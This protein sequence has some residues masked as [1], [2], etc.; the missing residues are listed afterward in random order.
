M[1]D[2]PDDR[3]A[4]ALAAS[5]FVLILFAQRFFIYDRM[6]TFFKL[7]LQSW[8]LL[9]VATA[10]L[11]FGAG[12]R[13]SIGRWSIPARLGAV[14]LALA[15]LFTT[16]TAGRAAVSRH[17]APYVGPSLDGLGYLQKQRPGEYLAVAWLR[18]NV[19]GTP[20]VLEAQGPSY[21]DF[22]RISMLTGLPTVLGWDYPVSYTHL[23][24][25]TSDLV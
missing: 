20:V 17:F 7:Y 3:F 21:Q 18:Q 16:V 10:A 9:A 19:R 1:P 12:R 15:A 6:N 14:V 25:P 22:G 11:A 13:G 23:T 2:S 5:A 24:L 8:I 4:C